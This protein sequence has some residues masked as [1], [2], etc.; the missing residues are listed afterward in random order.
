MVFRLMKRAARWVVPSA[1]AVLML[2]L[3]PSAFGQFG[4]APC[5]PPP[6][7]YPSTAPVPSTTPTTPATPET[8]TPP[9][10]TEAP[11]ADPLAFGA[12]GGGESF[13]GGAPNVIGDGG[14]RAS[15]TSQAAMRISAIKITENE[16]PPAKPRLLRLQLPTTSGHRQRQ[17]PCRLEQTFLAAAPRSVLAPVY[18]T[19]D[20]ILGIRV[21]AT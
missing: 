1:S 2:S 15:G 12:T 11:A 19:N 13:A 10:P 4:K 5:P 3:V 9:A 14:V 8:P 17:P 20:G 16:A 7:P 6:C 21:S 18:G